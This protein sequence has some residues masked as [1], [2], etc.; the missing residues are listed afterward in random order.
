MLHRL[1]LLQPLKERKLNCISFYS[2]QY[3]LKE[4]VENLTRYISI[5]TYCG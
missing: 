1:C 3:N 5:F 2:S 4:R